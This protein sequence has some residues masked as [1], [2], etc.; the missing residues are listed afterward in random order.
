MYKE[1]RTSLRNQRCQS[2]QFIYGYAR[3]T[4]DPYALG[5]VA[6]YDIFDQSLA[7]GRRR[8]SKF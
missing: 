4:Q 1:T 2:Q 3:I 6:G 7:V 5:P 8:G